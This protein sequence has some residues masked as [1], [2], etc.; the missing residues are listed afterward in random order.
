[1]RKPCPVNA[2]PSPAT[3]ERILDRSGSPR[4]CITGNGGSLWSEQDQVRL[5]R[6]CGKFF[7]RVLF[8]SEHIS[9]DVA[10]TEDD[11]PAQEAVQEF[12]AWR[13][14]D[15][16]MWLWARAVRKGNMGVV[17]Q[18]ERKHSPRVGV[19]VAGVV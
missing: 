14:P 9:E 18:V 16:L 11:G 17:G 12:I 3:A 5:S 19:P 15:G 13:S 1:M 8:R 6:D 7:Q 10:T 2:L 4:V